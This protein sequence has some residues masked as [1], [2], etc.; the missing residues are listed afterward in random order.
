MGLKKITSDDLENTILNPLENNKI[1]YILGRGC[2]PV[3]AAFAKKKFE[4]EF[5]KLGVNLKFFAATSDKQLIDLLNSN[6]PFE[7]FFLAPGACG[8]KKREPNRNLPGGERTFDETIILVKNHIPNITIK[9]I[10]DVSKFMNII[11][12]ALNLGE[13]NKNIEKTSEDW[14]FVD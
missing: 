11:S 6:M 2:D 14:P 4:T 3:R 10:E 12:E 8:I 1:R 13:I 9:Y 5:N 7:L